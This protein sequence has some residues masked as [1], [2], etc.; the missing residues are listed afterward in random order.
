MKDEL[1]EIDVSSIDELQRIKKEQDVVLDRIEKMED[2]RGSV[3]AEVFERVRT[4]YTSR[5]EA[6]D[7]EAEPLKERARRQYAALRTVLERIEGAL[8]T[9]KMDREELQ[10]RHELGEYDDAAFAA[11]T[12]EQDAAVAGCEADLEEA[13]AL[14]ERFLSAFHS[15]DELEA[16]P[17]AE[18]APP[19]A[20]PKTEPPPVPAEEPK[21]AA[22]PPLPEDATVVGKPIPKQLDRTVAI[23][24]QKPEPSPR[25]EDGTMIIQWP[26]L[27]LQRGG[28]KAEK[29][30]LVGSRTI[31]GRGSD[32]D[33]VLD[34]KKVAERHAEIFL[35]PDGHVIKDLGSTVGT[36]VNGVE[37]SEH[38]LVDRDKVQVGEFTLTFAS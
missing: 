37:V 9:A 29:H 2:K 30:S 19:P 32:C 26:T 20:K 10:L 33:I 31:I 36:L 8:A 27:T 25:P 15:E 22:E 5:L 7:R 6:L 17:A 23:P 12:K 16:A 13:G 14:R 11:R 21:A 38:R 1:A 34:G 3:T 18:P 28:G 35:G 4:D 24:V